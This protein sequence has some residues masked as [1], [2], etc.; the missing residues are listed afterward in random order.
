MGDKENFETLNGQ[1]PLPL[2]EFQD[3]NHEKKEDND[4]SVYTQAELEGL[5]H[6]VERIEN[7]QENTPPTSL[8]E[9]SISL[10]PNPYRPNRR[11]PSNREMEIVALRQRIQTIENMHSHRNHDYLEENYDKSYTQYL[12]RF[13]HRFSF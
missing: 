9:S 4:L 3:I 2:S 10:V 1:E 11:I 7:K 5:Y 6:D 13:F 8:R 12:P